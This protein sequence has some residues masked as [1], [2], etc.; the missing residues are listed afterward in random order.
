[1]ARSG[2]LHSHSDSAGQPPSGPPG[3]NM[4][5]RAINPRGSQTRMLRPST[6]PRAWRSRGPRGHGHRRRGTTSRRFLPIQRSKKD[7]GVAS[8]PP[9]DEVRR[10]K[11]PLYLAA[12]VPPPVAAESPRWPPIAAD[13]APLPTT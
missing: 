5:W 10:W 1:V 12:L 2:A 9:G 3:S 8:T 13:Y 4:R 11:L 7:G 6:T